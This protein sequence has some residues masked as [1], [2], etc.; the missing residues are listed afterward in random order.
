MT[1]DEIKAEVDALTSEMAAKA[2]EIP[3]AELSV[4]ANQRGFVTIWSSSS[5]PAFDGDY[6]KMFYADAPQEMIAAARAYIAALPDPA[7]IGE[8]K[9]IRALADAIDI[10]TEY[11]LPDKV[12]AP[13]RA[14]IAEVNAVLLE[15]PK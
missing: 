10:A 9:F 2:V 4:K 15:G 13:V 8:R 3:N 14:S 1:Y 12:V 5:A 6:L 11:S 7:T